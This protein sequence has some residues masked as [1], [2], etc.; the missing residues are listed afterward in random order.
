[1]INHSFRFL[2]GEREVTSKKLKRWA[3]SQHV[4]AI[5]SANEGLED[6]PLRLA[7]LFLIMYV[8]SFSPIG[9]PFFFS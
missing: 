5:P 1:V 7:L 4:S 6:D 2:E 3:A 9:S 8:Q